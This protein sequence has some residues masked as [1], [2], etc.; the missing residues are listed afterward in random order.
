ME[1]MLL[2]LAV[3]VLWLMLL[4]VRVVGRVRR[5]P[6]M[7]AGFVTALLIAGWLTLTVLNGKS[8]NPADYASGDA[9]LRAMLE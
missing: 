6:F 9:A 2:L 4:P 1:L 7:S 3:P 5:L 8:P